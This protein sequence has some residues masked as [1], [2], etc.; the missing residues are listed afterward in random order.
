MKIKSLLYFEKQ[1]EIRFRYGVPSVHYY[2]S[3]LESA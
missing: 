3:D 1:I 2:L